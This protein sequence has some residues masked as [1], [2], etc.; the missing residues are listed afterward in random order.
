MYKK[1][2]LLVIFLL[3]VK[4]MT[5][6]QK[7][8][9]V[10]ATNKGLDGYITIGGFKDT[11]G[12]YVGAPYN[13]HHLVNQ[14]TGSISSQMK[15]GIMKIIKDDKILIGGGVQPVND[16]NKINAFLGYNPLNSKDLK[17][18]IIGN[19]TGSQ[20]TPGLGLSYKLK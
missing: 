20:F 10:S 4:G 8:V 17:L 2:L 9:F 13:D 16:E 15:F 5:Y 14:K 6:G 1:V 11:W 18:W 19:V 12:L 7:E 3:G